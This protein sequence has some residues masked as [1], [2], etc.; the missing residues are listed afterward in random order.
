MKQITHF[1]LE[2]ESPNLMKAF[3]ES[4]FAYCPLGQMFFR[5]RA[6]N[7]TS[8]THKRALRMVFG[9][10]DLQ[11]TDLCRKD[12]S[13]SIHHRNTIETFNRWEK[14]YTKLKLIFQIKGCIIILKTEI[15]HIAS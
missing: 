3:I 10:Y 14:K 1:F 9:N 2:G 4:K 15:V 13:Y 12:N 11:F 8:Y 7:R 5:R 6:N